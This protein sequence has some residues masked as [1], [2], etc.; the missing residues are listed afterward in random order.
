M[1]PN[2]ITEQGK[3]ILAHYALKHGIDTTRLREWLM[4]LDFIDS[5]N[6]INMYRIDMYNGKYKGNVII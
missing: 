3:D 6:I 4:D 5:L 2:N 1:N